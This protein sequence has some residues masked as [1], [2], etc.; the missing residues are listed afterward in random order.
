MREL[1]TW[2]N[3]ERFVV[4]WLRERTGL[5]VYTET[6]PD[7]DQRI[8]YLRVERVGG[9]RVDIDRRVEIEIEVH[10][11]DRAGMWADVAQVEAAMHALAANGRATGYVDDV[12]ETFS[13]A[14]D[15][16]PNRATRRAVAT[17]TLVVR[18]AR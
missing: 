13:F 15:P 17:F 18:P 9:S 14:S 5:T 4:A 2:I 8:P 10:A 6:D 11:A 3:A 7:A 16:L 1:L 12:E